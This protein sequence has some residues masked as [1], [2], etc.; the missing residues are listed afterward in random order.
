[1]ARVHRTYWVVRQRYRRVG[2]LGSL[3]GAVIWA[4]LIIPNVHGA[5]WALP[6]TST[7]MLPGLAAFL[8][9]VLVPPLLARLCW[10]L[11]RRRFFSDMYL[12]TP[13]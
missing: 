1:M 11:H 6:A 2:Y 3:L 12:I 5:Q 7:D 13:H 4:V 8:A 10:R 9:A